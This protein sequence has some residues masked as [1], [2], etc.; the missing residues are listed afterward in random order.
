VLPY[1]SP[2]GPS[3]TPSDRV[4]VLIEGAEATCVLRGSRD[5]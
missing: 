3:R 5:R 1:T 2:A 4:P